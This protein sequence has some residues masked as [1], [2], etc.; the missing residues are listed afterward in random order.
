MPHTTA[1]RRLAASLLGL[2]AL[3][4]ACGGTPAGTTSPAASVGAAAPGG[5]AGASGAPASGGIASPADI[6]NVGI[7]APYSLADLPAARADAIQAGIAKDLG[8]FAKAVHVTVKAVQQNGTAAAYLMV[9]AFPRGTLSDNI[10]SQIITDLSMGAES[11]FTSTLIGAVPV[12]FG[13]MNGGSVAVFRQGD[14]ALITL[15]PQSTD[16]TQIETALVQANG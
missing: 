16:L 11:T 15:S 12:S 5:T 14:L 13:T 3:V 4:A 7:G 9:V 8:A 2:A 1:S 10:Y 6:V